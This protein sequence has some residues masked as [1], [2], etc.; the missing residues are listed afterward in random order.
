MCS[1]CD[2]PDKPTPYGEIEEPLNAIILKILLSTA[3]NVISITCLAMTLIIYCIFK[4][5][6]TFPGC[7]IMA[8]TTT[9][10]VAQISF[11]I[12]PVLHDI[13]LTCITLCALQ[14]YSW[15][16][17]FGWMNIIAFD[18]CNIVTNIMAPSEMR[19]TKYKLLCVL[20]ALGTPGILV[21][22]HIAVSHPVP[23]FPYQTNKS[24]W[25]AKGTLFLFF[26]VVPVAIAIMMNLVA[27][28]YFVITAHFT[29]SNVQ[30][31]NS[32]NSHK[33]N[34]FMHAKLF[35][36]MG[37]TWLFGLLGNISSFQWFSYIFTITSPMQGV[38]IFIGFGMSAHVQE[39]CRGSIFN[40]NMSG[41][42]G[43]MMQIGAITSRDCAAANSEQ[44]AVDSPVP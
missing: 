1:V 25:L 10:L 2:M 6:H 29:R 38:L 22:T 27:F 41:N 8:L 23:I 37:V 34:M 28:L 26:F 11:Q 21:A 12:G 20:H 3:L 44:S 15:L 31:V 36:L 9:L 14:Q 16:S 7:L 33:R 17:S 43:N 19:S 39:L 4:S 42:G 30:V 35:S 18:L 5:L 13:H 24:C 40:G 32:L